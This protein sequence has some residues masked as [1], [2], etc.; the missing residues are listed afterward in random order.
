MAVQSEWLVAFSY[1][2]KREV[3]MWI[4]IEPNGDDDH[5]TEAIVWPRKGTYICSIVRGIY[6]L[7]IYE[8]IIQRNMGL[9]C[10]DFGRQ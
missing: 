1:C 4:R 3:L 9:Q 8:D 6:G 5:I 10:F 7:L 2:K